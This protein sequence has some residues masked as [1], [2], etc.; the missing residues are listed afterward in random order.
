MEPSATVASTETQGINFDC[1]KYRLEY[2]PEAKALYLPIKKGSEPAMSINIQ[3][4]II[5]LDAE[6]NVIGIEVLGLE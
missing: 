2:D 5:D 6:G 1:D 3:D 4:V